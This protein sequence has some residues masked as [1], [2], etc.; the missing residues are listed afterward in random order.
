M[1]VDIVFAF[2]AQ[3]PADTADQLLTARAL[4]RAEPAPALPLPAVPDAVPEPS[5]ARPADSTSLPVPLASGWPAQS[6][7]AAATATG[8]ATTAQFVAASA[9][10]QVVPGVER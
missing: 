1:P 9:G 6:D 10:I 5:S 7:A 2:P 4:S 8:S 3:N